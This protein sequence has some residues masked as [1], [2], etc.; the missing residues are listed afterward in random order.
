MRACEYGLLCLYSD[1]VVVASCRLLFVVV[2]VI[3]VVG[4]VIVL[5]LA[6]W[7]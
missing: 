2:D 7:C 4:V 5:L 6:V 1:S 3:G